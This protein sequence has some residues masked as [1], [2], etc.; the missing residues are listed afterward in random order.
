MGKE[1]VRQ[2]TCVMHVCSIR[3]RN[4]GGQGEGQRHKQH[5]RATVSDALPGPNHKAPLPPRKEQ[6]EHT[7]S[8]TFK[9]ETEFQEN[10]SEGQGAS[11][12]LVS[13]LAREDTG[14]R[15]GEGRSRS[16]QDPHGE[17]PWG[18]L[19]DVGQG[20]EAPPHPHAEPGPGH[21]GSSCEHGNRLRQGEET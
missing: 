21:L 8:Q 18:T 10:K 4:T 6:P 11:T 14:Y 3:E 17:M 12:C 13:R 9:E 16:R 1:R 2:C 19:N 5:P 15:P 7:H 20:S